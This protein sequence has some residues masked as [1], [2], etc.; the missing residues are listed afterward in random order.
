MVFGFLASLVQLGFVEEVL[1]CFMPVGHTHEDIDAF[2]SRIAKQVRKKKCLTLDDLRAR[3]LASSKKTKVTVQVIDKVVDVASWILPSCRAWKEDKNPA[4]HIRWYK[5]KG[6]V[7]MQ[8]RLDASAESLWVP[9][10][11][12]IFYASPISTVYPRYV[13]P[14]YRNVEELRSLIENVKEYMQT[15]TPLMRSGDKN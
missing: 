1:L 4:L 11:G 2:F 7:R 15:G 6:E 14:K 5:V 12:H 13:L 3:I 8:S 9:E 10:G